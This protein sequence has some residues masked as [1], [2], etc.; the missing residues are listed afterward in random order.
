DPKKA[1]ADWKKSGVNTV[2][3]WGQRPWF[4]VSQEETLDFYD[5]IGMP[6][7]RSSI[8]D[9]EAASYNLVENINGK[10]VARQALF[11]NWIKYLK[12]WVKAERNHPSIFIWSIENEIT[13]INIRNF[14]L[15]DHC[16]PEIRRAVREVMALD[17]TRPAMTDGGDALR[18]KSL[19]VYGNHYNEFPV[20]EYPDEA[21]TLGL[22]GRRHTMPG[23][24]PWPVGDDKPLFL[25]ESFFASGH[26]PSYFAQLSGDGAFLG[27][28]EARKGIGLFARMLSEGYRW[29]GVAAFHFWFGPDRA[30]AHYNSW[31]PVCVLCREWNGTF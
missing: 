22:A 5:R 31:Q 15:H 3:Y 13:F 25:G 4:G 21:Y 28:P 18:D 19:S 20:R 7:R 23:R 26:T 29:H 12:A 11:D 10:N 9:G 6:V 8:F 24:D 1:V 17:P 27:W 14:G 2:R 16:E 30:D